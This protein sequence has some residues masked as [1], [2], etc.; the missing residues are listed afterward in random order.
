MEEI[1]VPKYILVD[2]ENSLR[3]AAN[4]MDSRKRLTAADRSIEH[5]ERLVKWI[6]NGRKGD[7]PGVIPK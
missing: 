4:I 3:M 6:L 5:S 2:I 1:S 7:A